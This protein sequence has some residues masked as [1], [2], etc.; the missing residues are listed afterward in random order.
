[1]TVSATPAW[2]AL[3]AHYAETNTSTMKDMFAADPERFNKFSLEFESILLDFSKNRINEE[4]MKLLYGL[5][6]Q[7][8]VS[9]LAK[10]MFSGEKISE[11]SHRRM[12][13]NARNERTT[14]TYRCRVASY[15]AYCIVLCCIS[16]TNIV[17]LRR[18]NSTT[19]VM[20]RIE[21][22]L[23]HLISSTI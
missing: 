2:K 23:F 10:K 22:L 20:E 11:Y 14:Q 18:R 8:G 16:C 17:R 7:Q 6:Q 15:R 4:T 9:G 3:A 13:Y 19:T 12:Q 5:A 1:M 21:L